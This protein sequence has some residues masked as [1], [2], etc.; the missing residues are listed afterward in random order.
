VPV[1]QDGEI[2]G[3][4]T[5]TDL[6]KLWAEVP[7]PMPAAHLALRLEQSLPPEVLGLIRQAAE[8]AHD[9]GFAIYLV[10]GFVRD[11]LLGTPS[12]AD[13]DL[14]VEGDAVDLATRLAELNGGRAHAHARFGTAKWIVRP[15]LALDFVS[16]RTEFYEQPTV[17]PTVERGSLKSDLHR[18][19]FT[20]NTMAICLA[21]DRYGQLI[22]FYGGGADLERKLIRVLHNLSFVEDPT[23]ILRA[24]RLEQR[25]GFHIEARTEELIDDALPLLDRVSGERIRNELYLIFQEA[26]PARMLR[27]IDELGVLRRIDPQLVWDDWLE[28]KFARVDL[29]AAEWATVARGPGGQ[30]APSRFGTRGKRPSSIPWPLAPIHYLALLVFRLKEPAI[31][32][33]G[34]RLRVPRDQ[35]ELLQAIPSLRRA[36]DRLAAPDLKP[37]GVYALLSPFTDDALALLWVA[38]DGEVVRRKLSLY[39]AELRRV[40]PALTGHD[41][42]AMGLKPGPIYR[43]ILNALRDARLDGEIGTRAEEESMAHLIAGEMIGN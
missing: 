4:V 5:R 18:R 7:Q 15:D 25:L 39:Q 33:V 42:R 1:L 13:I 41:L 21:P 43:R 16:A 37:S 40:E 34:R 24:A 30:P 8:V 17:L 36:A 29:R 12:R 31:D 6:L 3:I 11:L 9:M 10:G 27:R 20:I 28:D 23:R 2:I 19:D 22:D 32:F 14:L 35:I 38:A 26:E